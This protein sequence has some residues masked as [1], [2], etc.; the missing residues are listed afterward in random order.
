MTRTIRAQSR[1]L[2]AAASIPVA[3][4]LA[5]FAA[6]PAWAHVKVDAEHPQRGSEAVLTF[7]VPNESDSGASTTQFS[8]TLPNPTS[9]GAEVLPG[10]TAHLNRDLKAGTVSSVTWTA[11]PGA[12][13]GPDQF[14]L[15]HI[16][17]KLPD[18]DTASYPATQTY[19]DGTVVKWDQPPLPNGGEPDHPVPTL[20]LFSSNQAQ[21]PADATDSVAFWVAVAGVVLGAAGVVLGLLSWRRR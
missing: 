15:F 6:A 17:A 1:V 10:W 14:A 13:I 2:I 8:V 9:A 21:Q 19:S 11:A 5:L 18:S 3:A 7:E 20:T 4:F 12:G 16:S